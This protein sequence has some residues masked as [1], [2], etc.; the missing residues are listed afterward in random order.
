MD[1]AGLPGLGDVFL[2]DTGIFLNGDH[3]THRPV[4]VV[5]APRTVT[6]YLTVIQRS[7]TVKACDGID[8]P[9]D[10]SLD[11]DRDGRWVLDYQRG[12]RCDEFLRSAEHKG[13]LSDLYLGPLI[14]KWEQT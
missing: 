1:D 6:D 2:T 9:A 11:L 7:S 8:H 14:D 13:M 3:A 4:V 12:V 5:R 10:P